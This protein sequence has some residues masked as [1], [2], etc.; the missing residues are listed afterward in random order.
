MYFNFCPSNCYLTVFVGIQ[1]LVLCHFFLFVSSVDYFMLYF[2]LFKLNLTFQTFVKVNPVQGEFKTTWDSMWDLGTDFIR[3]MGRFFDGI[4]ECL[5]L[6]HFR[7]ILKFTGSWLSVLGHQCNEFRRTDAFIGAI[8]YSKLYMIYFPFVYFGR[9]SNAQKLAIR[10]IRI[11]KLRVA[12]RKFKVRKS[13]LR[14]S[15]SLVHD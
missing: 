2:I 10:L 6:P 14:Q 12:I 5:S 3:E 15:A 4:N 7:N 11:L 9:L 8:S 1:L 13:A